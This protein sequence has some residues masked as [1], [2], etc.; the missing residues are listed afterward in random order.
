M[1]YTP[2]VTIKA[3]DI[4][5]PADNNANILVLDC[6]KLPN[7]GAM[8]AAEFVGVIAHALTE[9]RVGAGAMTAA[10]FVGVIAHV[11]TENRV[12]IGAMTAEFVGAMA[13]ALSV[14]GK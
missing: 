12:G 9:N 7:I 10:E 5:I 13:H 1:D 6:S 2:Q 14:D 11:L 4:V 3:G 8:T